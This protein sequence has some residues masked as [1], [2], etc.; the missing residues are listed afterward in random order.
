REEAER[1]EGG[2]ETGRQ[3]ERRGGPA[4]EAAHVRPAEA[5][6]PQAAARPGD[7]DLSRVQVAGADQ[8]EGA[9]REA[10]DDVRVVAEQD[11]QVGLRVGYALQ[12]RPVVPVRARIDA[13]D[14]HLA[15]A[16]LDRARVV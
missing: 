2:A 15:A 14:L 9:G 5:C 3:V 11:P 10:V 16:Q 13:D 7:A 8:V 12:V 4:V 6:Q 1:D